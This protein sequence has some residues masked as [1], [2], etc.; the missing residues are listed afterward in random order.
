VEERT[1]KTRKTEKNKQRLR[2]EKQRQKK[3][4]I[5]DE[6]EKHKGQTRN[7]EQR[8]EVEGERT[9]R[10]LKEVRP[11]E[12]RTKNRRRGKKVALASQYT[13]A[14]VFVPMHQKNIEDKQETESRGE[15]QKGKEPREKRSARKTEAEGRK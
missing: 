15:R 7:R 5:E 6:E 13:F 11:E 2:N 1:K 10:E 12:K 8:R 3:K 4:T 14:I 9:E